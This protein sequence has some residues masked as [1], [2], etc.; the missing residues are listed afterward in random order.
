MLGALAL[1]LSACGGD[2]NDAKT[3]SAANGTTTSAS[4]TASSGGSGSA[5]DEGFNPGDWPVFGRDR[6]NTRYAPQDSINEETISRLGE[7]WHSDLG[8]NQWLNEAFPIVV[9]GVAYVTTSTNEIYAFDGATGRVKWKYAPKVDFSLSSGVGGY[10]IVVNRG[11]AVAD[12]KVYMLTFDCRL[13][14]VS[15]ATGEE[16]FSTQVDDPRTGAYETMSPTVYNGLV[17]V[18]NSGSDQGVGGFVAAYDARTGREVWRFDT[19]PPVGQGWRRRDTGGGTVYMAPTIDTQ[20]N[21][22]IFGTGNPSPA[23]VG[24]RR[25]GNNLYT[26]S[27]VALDATTGRYVWHHQVVA[28]DLWDYDAASPVVLFDTVVDGERKRMVAEAGKS[29]WLVMLDAETGRQVH[30]RLSFVRQQRSKPTTT[31]TLQCPGPLGGSQY[32]PL[33]YSPRVD[34][35]YVSGIDFC[36]ML[37]VSDERLPGESRFG[38][39]RTFPQDGRASGSFSAVDMKTGRFIWRK[40]MST[41]MGAGAM[42][43]GADIVFTVDQLGWIYGFDAA[44]GRELWKANIGLAGAAAPVLYTIDGVDYIGVATGGSGLTSSNDFGPIG[45]RFTV[46]KLDGRRVIPARAPRNPSADD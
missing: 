35:V 9:D 39:T 36:F 22:V 29:G 20:T 5:P 8:G 10:G 4:T 43:N 42:V 28:H 15:A 40:R 33:A 7:A 3:T 25:P 41:P 23:I 24:T 46:L 18:G 17:Y 14:A 26:S 27:L 45:S 11:V 13:K 1:T 31:P 37:A 32:D 44:D 6:D 12:G 34:A 2:D 21:R 38:G 30:D 19:I 16:V